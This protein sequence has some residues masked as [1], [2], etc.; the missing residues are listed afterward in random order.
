M[1]TDAAAPANTQAVQQPVND[2]GKSATAQTPTGDAANQQVA[3]DA[4]KAASA[5]ES[6]AGFQLPE[7]VALNDTVMTEFTGLAKSHNLTQEAAQKFVDLGAKMATGFGEVVQKSHADLKAKFQ[8]ELQND[9]TIGG[10]RLNENLAIAQRAVDA[11][12]TPELRK[13]LEDSGL[14]REPN[15]VRFLHA[16]GKTVAEDNAG[17]VN[18]TGKGDGQKSLADR[19]YGGTA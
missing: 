1:T 9:P 6:Y 3:P 13:M 5:P 11:Y 12:G 7:G 16:V 19:L 14:N 4:S 2:D 17:V 15:L 8:T 18:G 10:E